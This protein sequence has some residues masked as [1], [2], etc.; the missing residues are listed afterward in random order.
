MSLNENIFFFF[1]RGCTDS[2]D[3]GC[4]RTGQP[5]QV[6]NPITSASI[7]TS[8]SF[9]FKFGRIEIRA[10]MPK[11]DWIWPGE[12]IVKTDEL[13]LISVSSHSNLTGA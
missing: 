7:K 8:K 12:L 9:N 13:T 11:G 1:L 6:V 3:N 2:T 4:L 10:K 5:N